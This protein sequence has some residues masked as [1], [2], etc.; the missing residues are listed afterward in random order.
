MPMPAYPLHC[1][2]AGC[3]RAAVYKI[4]ARW[5]DGVTQELK[6]YGLSCEECLG[7]HYQRSLVKQ[8]SCR[9]AQGETLEEPGIYALARGRRDSQLTRC[10]E[11]EERCRPAP[12]DRAG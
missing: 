5:S 6:T 11:Q 8:A 9:L 12:D 2:R 4:A 10:P 7:E 1:Y 3:G